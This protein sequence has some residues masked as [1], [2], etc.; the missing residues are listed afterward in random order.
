MGARYAS[1]AETPIGTTWLVARSANGDLLTASVAAAGFAVV[2][3]WKRFPEPALVSAA[4]VVGL[5][6]YRWLQSARVL[7]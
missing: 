7:R 2:L 1:V 6:T 3:L 5:L 4:G